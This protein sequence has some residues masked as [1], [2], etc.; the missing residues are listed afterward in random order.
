MELKEIR[1]LAGNHPQSEYHLRHVLWA[2]IGYDKEEMHTFLDTLA[3]WRDHFPD[4]RMSKIL[5]SIWAEQNSDEVARWFSGDL[6][7][8]RL[9]TIEKWARVAASEMLIDGKYSLA[10]FQT[11]SQFPLADYSLVVKRVQELVA[12][13]SDVTA[14][15]EKLGSGIPGQ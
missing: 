1:E 8:D 5:E 12:L 7:I 15:A 9:K 11:I 6:R 2:K 13:I 10:T 4:S 3:Y 14:Q